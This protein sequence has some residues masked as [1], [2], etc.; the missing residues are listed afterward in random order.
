MNRDLQ[1]AADLL[2]KFPEFDKE[3]A[4]RIVGYLERFGHTTF[5]T[6]QM[7]LSDLCVKRDE[8]LGYEWA[9][10]DSNVVIWTNLT[11]KGICTLVHLKRTGV[12]DLHPCPILYYMMDGGLLR[13]PIAKRPPSRG[14]KE[15][16]WVP[17]VL[18]IKK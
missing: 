15:P 17:T 4:E 7:S 14:Y 5:A 9:M 1:P 8:D 3:L 12:I 11:H 13:Y 16:H 6:L 18:F 10:A 2:E